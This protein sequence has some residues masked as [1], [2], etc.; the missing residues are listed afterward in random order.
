M[1]NRAMRMGMIVFAC[2]GSGCA[3]VDQKVPLSYKQAVAD[4][5]SDR[6]GSVKIEMPVCQEFKQKKEG[7]YVI[8]NVKNTWGMKTADT[9]TDAS[10]PQWIADALCTELKAAGFTP[11]IVDKLPVT[12]GPAVR[13]RV[14]K[15]WVE[16]DPGFWTVGAIGEVQLRMSVC[17]GDTIIKEFDVESKGQGPRGVFGDDVTKADSLRVALEICMKKVVPIVVE[18]FKE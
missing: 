5:H 9:V 16:Q 13:T 4:A 3:L 17:R 2:L 1:P 10:V 7:L 18:T 12:A 6:G 15:V 11:E 8:G 14:I